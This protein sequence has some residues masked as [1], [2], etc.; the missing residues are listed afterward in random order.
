MKL[1]T[2]LDGGREQLG[3]LR[4]GSVVPLESL[5]LLFA[6]MNDLILHATKEQLDALARAELASGGSSVQL[7]DVTVLA[8]MPCPRA[9][10]SYCLG[11]Y[12]AAHAE[13]SARYRT[14][15]TFPA[16]TRIPPSISP[17]G[18]TGPW[19]RTPPSATATRKPGSRR[20][21]L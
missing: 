12:D 18:S 1:L 11:L 4:S 13:E 3:L 14:N 16:M 8:P 21:G 2:Y 10:P 19:G 17:N 7:S 9:R 6:D 15:G 20:P 5:G